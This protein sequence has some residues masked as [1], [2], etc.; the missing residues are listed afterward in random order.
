M[1]TPPRIF[2]PTPLFDYCNR[3][4]G[5]T[6]HDFEMVIARYDEDI[7]WSDNYKSFRTVYNKGEPISNVESIFFDNKGHLAHTIL[8]HIITKYDCLAETTFFT[9]GSFNYRND[10]IIKDSRPCHRLF[11]EFIVTDPNAL[12]Y[13]PRHDIPRSS[14]HI[15]DY[16]ETVGAVFQRIFNIPYPTKG[17][18][19]GCGKIVS[20]GKNLILKRP[21]RFYEN[22]LE[23]IMSPHNDEEPSQHVYRTRGIY[24]ERFFLLFFK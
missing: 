24:I 5:K 3:L 20:V 17:Y 7:S 4:D 2:K 6:K 12:V 16:P 21:K 14:E 23:F 19:W 22:V 8:T 18:V 10:Q 13:I 15:H 9:H 11:S 1:T